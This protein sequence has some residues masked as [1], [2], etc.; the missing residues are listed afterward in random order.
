[1]ANEIIVQFVYFSPDVKVA[2]KDKI[3]LYSLQVLTL[4]LLWHG[5]NDAIHEGDGECVLTY[6]KFLAV[7][8]KVTRQTNY[9][10][11]AVLLQLQYHYLLPKREA[12]QLQW[13]RFVNTVGR[14][15]YNISCN[16][17]IYIYRTLESEAKRHDGWYSW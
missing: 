11:E 8:F 7:V 6:W 1:V 10:K 13:S 4:M 2:G 14:A 12:E 5:F 9:F 3:Y 17:H 16:L 15:D